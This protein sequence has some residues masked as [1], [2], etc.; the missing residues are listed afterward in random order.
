MPEELANLVYPFLTYGLRLK[1]RLASRELPDLPATQR[2]LQGLLFPASPAAHS[3]DFAGDQPG[4]AGFAAVAG[5][6]RFLG[7]RYALTCWIDE[8]MVADT[9]WTDKWNENKLEP[10]LYTSGERFWRFWA[11]AERAA[12]EGR[13][14]ALEAFLLCAM[15]GFRGEYKDRPE[16]L[17]TKLREFQTQIG[18]MGDWPPG[19]V[20]GQAPTNVPPLAGERRKQRMLA[21]AVTCLFLVVF[22]AAFLI[23]LSGSW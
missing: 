22:V 6:E 12:R 18:Q 16:E 4:P 7:I 5:T 1:E 11:Q 17:R 10:A 13:T 3:A 20:Y 8:I 15:L 14:D 9:P 19:H 2:A 21:L 23:V